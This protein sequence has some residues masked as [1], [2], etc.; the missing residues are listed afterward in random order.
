MTDATLRPLCAPSHLTHRKISSICHTA[1]PHATNEET[2]R[3]M[4]LV[5]SPRTKGYGAGFEPR[6]SRWQ[7]SCSAYT[8]IRGNRVLLVIPQWN[9]WD[10][11]PNGPAAMGSLQVSTVEGGLYER[12]AILQNASRKL[13]TPLQCYRIGQLQCQD[14]SSEWKQAREEP[15]TQLCW[16][17]NY[18]WGVGILT[19][20]NV[21]TNWLMF[22][23]GC[24]FGRP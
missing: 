17:E 3:S 1:S 21:S 9:E 5:Q 4:Q 12:F 20:Y 24:L 10:K 23:T 2:L 22:N 19:F 16:S 13:Y 15:P 7:G 11:C 8:A 18:K 14:S 6:S